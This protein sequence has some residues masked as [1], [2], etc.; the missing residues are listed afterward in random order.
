MI[1]SKDVQTNALRIVS[2][3]IYKHEW[4]FQSQADP[5]WCQEIQLRTV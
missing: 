2:E 1:L 4:P 3:D 5:Q